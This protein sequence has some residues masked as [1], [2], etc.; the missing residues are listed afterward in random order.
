MGVKNLLKATSQEKPAVTAQGGKVRVFLQEL[1]A[2][3]AE[4]P[5]RRTRKC[6]PNDGPVSDPSQVSQ[7]GKQVKLRRIKVTCPKVTPVDL[8]MQLVRNR[9]M[10]STNLSI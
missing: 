6:F 3:Q 9:F 2:E 8:V 4:E 5:F 1:V 7:T 10:F